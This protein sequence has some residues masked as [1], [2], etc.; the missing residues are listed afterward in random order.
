MSTSSLLFQQSPAYLT[1]LIL[2][3]FEIGVRCPY[4][5]CFV[6]SCLQDLFN[7]AHIIL[8]KLSWNFLFVCFVN[9]H[10]VHPYSSTDSTAARK[11]LP[12]ILFDRSDFHMTYSLSIAVQAFVSLMLMSFSVDETLIPR[13][14]NL[15]TSFRDLSFSAETSL[16]WLKHINSVLS[17]LTSRP[18]PPAARSRLCRRN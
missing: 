15:S 6:G 7:T 16:L 12:F 11:K 13:L 5:C 18:M 10:M 14:V 17:A 2:K 9:V 4:S 3:V 1:H 8:E